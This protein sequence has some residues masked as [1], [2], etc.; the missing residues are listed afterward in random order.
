MS[1][2]PIYVF[3]YGSLKKDRWN[4]HVLGASE[5]VADAVTRERFLLTDVGFP[6]MVPETDN[7]T[8]TSSEKVVGEVYKVIDPEVLDNLDGLEGVSHGHYKHYHTTVDAGGDTPI[9]VMTYVPVDS[10]RAC[11]NLVCNQNKDGNYVW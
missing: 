1:E 7:S 2:L 11:Q 8:Q 6:Y 3:V 4:H 5:F 10:D 9:D